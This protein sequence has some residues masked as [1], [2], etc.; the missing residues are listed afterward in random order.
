MKLEETIF[1][2][3]EDYMVI[4]TGKPRKSM[5]KLLESMQNC[6]RMMDIN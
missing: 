2:L 1:L 3:G 6:I 5:D 4:Y